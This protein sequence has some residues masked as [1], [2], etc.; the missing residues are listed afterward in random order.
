[1]LRRIAHHECLEIVRDGRFR[2]SAAIVI[3]LLGVA[4][5]AGW[6]QHREVT[7]QH[8]QAQAQ[9]RAH[10]LAQP[11]KDPH[12]AAHY[13]IYAFKPRMPLALFDTGVDPYTGVVAWLEA[14]KQN[15]FQHRPAQDRGAM[16]RFGELTAAATLQGLVPLLIIL[17]GVEAFAGEREQGTLRQL[18]SIGVPPRTVALGKLVGLATALALVLV[19]A[20]LIG[21]VALVWSTDDTGAAV[22]A[23]G[24]RALSLTGVYLAYFAAVACL[25]LAASARAGA[26]RP[27]LALLVAFWAINV[28]VAPR[29]ASE[30]GRAWH[31]TPTAFDFAQEV[32]R[33]T[34]G[35]LDAHAFTLRRSRELKVRLLR[36]Y[37][38][39]RVDELPV[40]FRGIDYLEREAHANDTFDRVYGHLWDAFRRQIAVQQRGALAAPLL[41]VRSLSMAL[42][43]TDFFHHQHFAAAAESYRRTLVATMNH[44]LAYSSSSSRLGYTA[45]QDVWARVPPF[46]YRAPSLAWALR[47]QAWSLGALAC[48]LLVGAAA[49]ARTVATLRIE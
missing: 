11:A 25:T 31:P 5:G 44:D 24:W 35:G 19:P 32:Q 1:M 6:T 17:L 12:S 9:T 33:A 48:W 27:A 49:L 40:N 46:A 3:A 21:S 7:A 39:T 29:L 42:A 18:A 22:A 16:V 13:G 14:H 23:A 45:G 36:D 30:L 4:L 37:S 43:G 15:E 2:V 28:V 38:V 41:G 34:Y 8:A 47:G 10:W 20:A 26:V